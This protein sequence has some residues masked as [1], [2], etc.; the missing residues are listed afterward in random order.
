MVEI[1]QGDCLEV[2]PTLPKARMIFADPPDNLGIKYDGFEDKWPSDW[3]YREWLVRVTLQALA[4]WSHPNRQPDS[5]WLSYYWRHD[6]EFKANLFPTISDFEKN[7][8]VKP[9]VW[10]FTFGQHRDSDCGSCFRPIVRF[11]KPGVKWNTDDIREPSARQ[12]EYNDPRA[13]PSGRVP[14]DVWDGVWQESRVCGTFKEKRKW[15]KNQH[16]EALIERMVR[17]STKPGDLVIDL[18]GGTF[19]TA[20]VCKRLGRDCISIEISPT[21]CAKGREELGLVPPV[22]EVKR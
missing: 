17:M 19:T 8:D 16:P 9:Y 22:P 6:F 11:S 7:W 18:F 20:R 2:M 12:R 15:H 10:W 5:F 14:G 3:H 4:Q 21:Y 13:D 1:I